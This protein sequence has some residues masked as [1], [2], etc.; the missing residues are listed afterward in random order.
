MKACL[1]SL[2]GLELP[3]FLVMMAARGVDAAFRFR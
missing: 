3:A 1:L 2:F